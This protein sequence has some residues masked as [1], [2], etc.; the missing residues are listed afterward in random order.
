MNLQHLPL[1]TSCTVP[2]DI[3][4]KSAM[5]CS[6]SPRKSR[7]LTSRAVSLFSFARGRFSPFG[8]RFFKSMSEVLSFAVPKNKWRG[9][10]QRGLS[11]VWQTLFTG[12][13]SPFEI[14]K[15]IRWAQ[16]TWP[17]LI[18][19]APYPP[20][21]VDAVQFQQTPASRRSTF[22]QNLSIIFSVRQIDSA[23]E[24]AVLWWSLSIAALSAN[25]VKTSQAG[26][27]VFL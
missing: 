8:K 12:G 4:C 9:L 1:F 3:P 20:G 18:P 11:Q 15:A 16:V 7:S 2:L 25:F 24:R 19:K 14:R 6:V 5:D 21:Y 13:K 26:G 23:K 22:F 10:Q 27:A 17:C